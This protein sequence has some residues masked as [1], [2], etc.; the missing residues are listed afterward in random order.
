MIK[1]N[2]TKL[3]VSLKDTSNLRQLILE[4][5]NLPLIILCGDEAW[6]GEHSYS[7]ASASKGSIEELGLYDD[8]V[9]EIWVDKEEYREKLENDLCDDEEYINMTDE[10]F[11]N[12][13][14]G[15]IAETEFVRAIVIYVG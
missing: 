11:D 9:D 15:K 3:P 1:T 4:N 10:E 5:P 6:D 2:D 8:V 14:D 12:M 13:I 7:S